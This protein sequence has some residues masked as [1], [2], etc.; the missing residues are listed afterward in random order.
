VATP[1]ASDDLT[2]PKKPGTPFW[3]LSRLAQR[4][5]QRQ[6]LFDAREAYVDGNHPLPN[7][8]RRYVRALRDIQSKAKTNYIELVH[9][10]TV[11]KLR[12]KGFQFGDK[13]EADK[14]AKRVWQFND[15]DFQAPMMIGS[16]AKFGFTYAYVGPPEEEDGEPVIAYRDPRKC[17]I[18]RDPN[19]PTKTL[20]G[21]EF[22]Q[23]PSQDAVLAI[24]YLPDLI[25]YFAAQSPAQ[26]VESFVYSMAHGAMDV[27]INEFEILAVRANPLGEVPL[28]RGDWVPA[29]GERGLAEGEVAWDIQDRINK[30][31]LDRL[32]ISNSQAYRQRWASGV[33]KPKT[34]K[35]G[36]KAPPWDPGADMIWVTE[37][38][39]ARFGDFEQAD[40]KQILEAIRDD[41]GDM[42]AITQTPVTSL[43]NRLINVS[44][45]TLNQAIS[46][47]VAKLRLR[48]DSMGFFF[49]RLQKL[50]FK[51]KGDARGREVAAETL[52]HSVE[53]RSF[54]EIAD[55]M[56]KWT[57]AGIPLQ[58]AMEKSGQ[59][60]DEEIAWAVEEAAKRRQEEMAREDQQLEKQLAVK[61][62][63]T[64]PGG[65]E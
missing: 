50:A 23:D 13:P 36:G 52:W 16:A 30:T 65:S 64:T 40:I 9:Q 32:V 44:G 57:A 11:Q 15:M 49:E 56:Q 51:Y 29:A 55:A 48:Q 2:N 8:D 33:A 35:G 10:T 37:N 62:T 54:A 7:G 24:L 38:K 17:E 5:L 42:V 39:E 28:V 58:L 3:W 22:W 27:S 20:A 46:G 45:E 4:L 43:T 18:E 21:L 60:T 19:R 12:V 53:T 14:D 6:A 26:G 41:V 61:Q 63:T 47:H 25:Y 34:T 31:V 1:G 59:F